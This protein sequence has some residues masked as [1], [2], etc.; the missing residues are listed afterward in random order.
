MIIIYLVCLIYVSAGPTFRVIS[1][2][3]SRVVNS[4][5]EFLQ[6]IAEYGFTLLKGLFLQFEVSLFLSEI[7]E[8]LEFISKL[9]SDCPVLVWI[10]QHP[11]LNEF[12]NLNGASLLLD[13]AGLLHRYFEELLSFVP[14]TELLLGTC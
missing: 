5:V 3:C 2:L 10:L 4:Y 9:I 11:V 1:A 8:W 6:L 12:P 13:F 7:F 14:E